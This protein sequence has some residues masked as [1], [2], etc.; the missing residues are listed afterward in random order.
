[1]DSGSLSPTEIAAVILGT[2]A[3]VEKL[4]DFAG[5]DWSLKGRREK[6]EERDVLVLERMKGLGDN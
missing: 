1:M 3:V 2:V 4:V 6:E 5:F